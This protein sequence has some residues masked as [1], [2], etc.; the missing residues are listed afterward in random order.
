MSDAAYR[1]KNTQKIIQYLNCGYRLGH[2]LIITYDDDNGS[3]DMEQIERII[4]CM[5]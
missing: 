1:A 3:I 2:D 5:L 4:G